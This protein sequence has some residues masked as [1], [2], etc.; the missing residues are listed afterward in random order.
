[1][2]LEIE[3]IPVYFPYQPYTVQV[4]FMQKVIESC[5]LGKNAL[6]ESPTGTGKTLSL[7]CGIFSYLR[8]ESMERKV[9][10]ASRTHSQLSNVVKELKKTIFR[11]SVSHIASRRQLC[12]DKEVQKLPPALQARQCFEKRKRKTCIYSQEDHITSFSPKLMQQCLDLPE[13]IEEAKRQLVCPY[14]CAQINSAKADLILSPYNYILDPSVRNH[15]PMDMF[16]GS[17]IVF[18]EAHNFPDQ[19]SDFLST[20][21]SFAQLQMACRSLSTLQSQVGQFMHGSNKS[22]DTVQ[23]CAVAP[24]LSNLNRAIQEVIKKDADIRELFNPETS[25]YTNSILAIQKDTQFIFDLFDKAGIN[26][27]NKTE[28][29]DLMDKILQNAINLRLDPGVIT[30]V[31]NIQSFIDTLFQPM[32]LRHEN[33]EYVDC[34]FSVCIT[35]EQKISLQCFTPAPGFL[36]L[37][38]LQPNNIILTSGTLS[39]LDSF[40]MDLGQRFDIRLENGHVASPDQVFVGIVA[41]GPDSKEYEF[42]YANRNDKLMKQSL[43]EGSKAVFNVV[44]SGILT[45]FP[46][47]A[48]MEEIAPMFKKM[49]TH[50]KIYCEPRDN[51]KTQSVIDLFHKD[52]TRGA[53]LLGVCR[54]KLSE[55]LDFSD[56]AARCVCVVG[57]PYPNAGDY[58]IQFKRD[59]LEKKQNGLG[60]QWYI[61]SA[62][63]AVNQAIGR[64]IRHKN[65]YAAILLFD[66]RYYGWKTKLS[67]WIRPSIHN[68]NNWDDLLFE[69]RNFYSMKMSGVPCSERPSPR[70]EPIMIKYTK[71]TVKKEPQST[72]S[73]NKSQCLQQIKETTKT[74]PHPLQ[75]SSKKKEKGSVKQKPD[76]MSFLSSTTESGESH[77]SKSHD[78][79][80]V[81]ALFSIASD[82]NSSPKVMPA[83]L[84]LEK[85]P[86]IENYVCVFCSSKNKSA[87]KMKR[88]PCGHYSCKDCWEMAQAIGSECQLC[89]K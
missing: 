55:G 64:A 61:E 34:F 83:R 45:F 31:E 19:C 65:D 54:G 41:Q 27:K 53:A 47:F 72:V 70:N 58:K 16:M 49:T 18:D 74:A 13:F 75:L 32:H 10:Y 42:T 20:D 88:L 7:L 9:V 5:K 57:I 37:M 1:M 48:F 50:K 25:K 17:I 78:N 79:P 33:H 21:L 73:S 67:K 71:S 24:R 56:D 44:P 77:R 63:R 26:E 66:D 84:S 30:A 8:Q 85:K 46:S 36:Q 87:M 52:A 69:L 80:M 14:L 51:T 68:Y 2:E 11:P 29:S 76:L 82:S 62:I 22:I 59:W 89:N 23:L 35:S 43:V 40:A 12:L 15:L 60:S 38:N 28:I 3:D 4:D 81:S 39:P 6:L 86:K